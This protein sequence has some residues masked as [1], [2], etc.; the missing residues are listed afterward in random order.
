MSIRAPIHSDLTGSSSKVSTTGTHQARPFGVKPCTFVLPHGHWPTLL[1][2][3]CHHFPA[4]SREVWLSRFSRGLVLD[5]RQRPLA[6]DAPHRAGARIYYFR[7]VANEPTIPFTESILYQ[8]EH[9]LVAD[10]P[11][12]LPVV[13]SGGYVTQTLLSRLM[14]RL[15]NSEL[16]PLHRIDRHTAGLV[17]FSLQKG[18]RARYQALFS[19]QQIE[20]RYEAVAPPLPQLAF[21]HSR[22]SRIER[23]ERFFLSQEVPGSVNARSQI[24]VLER[25]EEWWRYGLSPITGKKHQLRLHMAALGAPI[26]NDA[27]Y[28]EVDDE[29]AEDYS[30]P[31]QLLARAIRFVDP[32]TGVQHD[33]QSRL[34]LQW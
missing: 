15:G 17:L 14:A 20:K 3:L 30:R 1:E 8:D 6:A 21:P 33:F 34:T 26:C 11:H 7:E 31:L 19:Q 4:I 27:F 5:E 18:S 9:L 29:L 10:K 23:A 32:V 25:R 28:P 13:P 2:G 16:Q 22:A 24:E 12:F